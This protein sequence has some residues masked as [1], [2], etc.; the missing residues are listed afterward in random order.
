MPNLLSPGLLNETLPVSLTPPDMPVIPVVDETFL[1]YFNT[2]IPYCPV[3]GFK[4]LDAKGNVIDFADPKHED[5][6]V[7]LDFDYAPRANK[8]IPNPYAEWMPKLLIRAN[9][10]YVN[11]AGLQLRGLTAGGVAKTMNLSIG[12]CGNETMSVRNESA[13]Y[14]TFRHAAVNGTARTH[15]VNWTI[16]DGLFEFEVN[17]G[18]HECYTSKLKL[19]RDHEYKWVWEDPDS[20]A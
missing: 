9:L 4:L 10:T 8:L 14:Y 5:D 19:Y 1:R 13:I 2:S 15:T 20:I 16:L 18:F 17:D 12:V 7:K 3:Y 6:V 11:V